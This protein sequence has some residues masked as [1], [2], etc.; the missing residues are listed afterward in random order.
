MK[1][2]FHF[3]SFHGPA[4]GDIRQALRVNQRRNLRSSS[5]SRVIGL[6]LIGVL[7]STWVDTA[8]AYLDPG[9][10]SILLQGLLAGF[11]GLAVVGRLYWSRI[12]GFFAQG[13]R[14]KASDDI[15]PVDGEP[16]DKFEP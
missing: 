6:A 15:D 8:Y 5:T 7:A 3:I 9:T 2:S 16:A 1:V 11:A 14:E 4:S 12:K 10:G 13:N